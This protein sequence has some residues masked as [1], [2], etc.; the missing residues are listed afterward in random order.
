MYINKY[1]IV[2]FSGN[3]EFQK[4][5]LSWCQHC[6]HEEKKEKER[7]RAK[8]SFGFNKEG[9]TWSIL[10]ENTFY[11][12]LRREKSKGNSQTCPVRRIEWEVKQ[13]NGWFKWNTSDAFLRWLIWIIL[14]FHWRKL[15]LVSGIF[16]CCKTWTSI[17]C[18]HATS[19]V[20][21]DLSYIK[22][23]GSLLKSRLVNCLY[24]T[25]LY[26]FYI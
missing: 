18:V 7:K 26:Y 5:E 25:C 14:S 15:D 21:F 22:R 2:L 9:P 4:L 17:V 16:T 11:Q 6:L 3:A 13:P 23:H 10:V 19:H 24:P 20:L 8:E 12:M 1:I